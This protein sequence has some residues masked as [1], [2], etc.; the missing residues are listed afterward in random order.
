M[1]LS[2]GLLFRAAAFAVL[3]AASACAPDRDQF[4]P[5]CPTTA[6][7]TPTAD[8]SIFRPGSNGRD[9]TALMLAGRMESIRGKCEPGD[10]KNTVNATVTVGAVL[11]RGPAMPGN[12][13]RVPVFVAVTEGNRIL[14]KHI[15]TLD[16]V[17][18]SNVDRITVATP[19]VFMVLPVS[20]T[21]SAAAYQILAG[22]QLT[23]DQLAT[24][25]A[26]AGQ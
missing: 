10:S 4:P 15:Y 3:L 11:S 24:N 9:L 21:M 12:A 13:A 18:P 2:P 22:F 20:P 25:R 19:P 23:P 8:V 7:L 6:F 1:S 17:F 5:A 26:Q 14:D 16:A